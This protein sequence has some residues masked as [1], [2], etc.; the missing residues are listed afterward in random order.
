MR[1]AVCD[2]DEAFRGSFKNLLYEYANT[3]RLGL[4]VDVFFDGETLLSSPYTYD[5]VFLDFKMTGR[6]GLDTA[7]IL[8]ERDSKCAIVFIT[9][10]GYVAKNTH[11]VAAYRFFEKPVA[12]DELF[13]ALDRYYLDSS[14]ELAIVV[15]VNRA[16]VRIMVTDICY[17]EASNKSC[18]IHLGEKKLYVSKTL[19]KVSAMLPPGTFLK[20]HRS[21]VVNLAHVQGYS[22]EYIYMKNGALVPV[23]KPNLSRFKSAFIEYAGRRSI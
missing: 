15:S 19:D 8:R 20:V 22:N 9:N 10:Y 6:T 14:S 1:F 7:R 5:I 23:S 18:N 11:E 16:K 13:S 2:D 12:R 4:L 3:R 21:F 17:L